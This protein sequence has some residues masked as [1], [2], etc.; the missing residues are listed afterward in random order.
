M[1]AITSF[2]DVVDSVNENGTVDLF[3]VRKD[4]NISYKGKITL[5][6]SEFRS[7]IE[8]Y[9]E[10]EFSDRTQRFIHGRY[11]M[12]FDSNNISDR[13]FN[14]K[15]LGITVESKSKTFTTKEEAE[16]YFNE[17]NLKSK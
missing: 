17:V 14:C 5:T 8:N 1:S 11:V 13:T 16:K 12:N 2:D 3:F 15:D 9:L 10:T 6:E 4:D 7:N